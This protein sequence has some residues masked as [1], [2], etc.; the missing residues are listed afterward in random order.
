MMAGG[1]MTNVIANGQKFVGNQK[2]TLASLN[3]YYIKGLDKN[4]H[5]D[6]L[7]QSLQT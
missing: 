5:L 2:K 3:A 6:T 4:Q 7:R 1:N